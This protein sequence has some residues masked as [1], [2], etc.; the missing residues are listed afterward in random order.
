MMK[1][2]KELSGGRLGRFARRGLML[3]AVTGVVSL[4]AGSFVS[5]ACT[6][7]Y[8]GK[9]VTTDGSILFG[10]TEDISSAHSK[11]FLV[12]E[13]ETHEEGEM[14]EDVTGFTMPLPEYTYRFTT[15]EDDPG[16]GGDLFGEVGTNEYGVSMSATESASPAS[17]LRQQ[18]PFI[19]DTGITESSMVNVV[20]PCVKTAREGIELLA[21]I[22]DTY[23]AGEGNTLMIGD[24]NECWYMEILTGHQYVAIKMPDDKAAIMP[25]CFMLEEVDVSDTENVIASENLFQVAEAAGTLVK[26][27]S[28]TVIHVRKSYSGSMGQGNSYRIWGGQIIFN[29]DL[30]SQIQPTDQ[31][32]PMFVEPSEKVSVKTMYRIAGTRYEGT[33]YENQGT[34]IGTPRSA[35]C[36]IMQIRPDMPVELE[37]I[38]WLCM[39]SAD[40]STFLPFYS[41]AI[42]DTH[43]AYQVGEVNYNEDSAYWTFRGLATLAAS[44][45]EL[46]AP[47]LKAYWSDYMD[48]LIARQA[49]VDEK[50]M[51]LYE[52]NPGAVSSKATDLGIALS[53]DAL[54]TAKTLYGD[55][56]RAFAS[57]DG[58]FKSAFVPQL[59]KNQIYSNYSYDLVYDW[60]EPEPEE[61]FGDLGTWIR[62]M[63]SL[64]KD[65]Y[66]KESWAAL[67]KAV[68]AARAVNANENASRAQIDRAITD[69]IQAFGGLEYGVQ[70]QHLEIA[71]ATA[72][73]ILDAAGDYEE[74]SLA[75]LKAVIEEAQTVLADE[76][77]TQDAV[78]QA[79]SKVIDAIAQVIENADL[80]SLESL[81]KAVESLDA[82]KYTSESYQ[83]LAQAIEAAKQVLADP[84]RDESQLAAAYTQLAE[85]VRGLEMKGNKAALSAVIEKAEGILANAS[86]YTASSISGLEEALAAAKAVYDKDDATMQEIAQAT[87]DLTNVLVQ[88]RLKGDLDQDGRVSTADSALLLQYTAEMADL[89]EAQYEGADVDGNGVVDTKDAVL[90]LQYSA[91]KISAF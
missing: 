32:L 72:Q 44:N 80:S 89:D 16:Y 19:R 68:E 4:A 63:E 36:H 58:S 83:A 15:C 37:T 73:G 39:G 46:V 50:M 87:E 5:L 47:N 21:D 75:A 54:K 66:T 31:D 60:V 26:G 74:E 82:D 85:A 10:R 70:R 88:A 55:M 38:E 69:L 41:A 17:A 35:E 13:A 20:L 18:D 90:I 34:V 12:H 62:F 45:R 51:A 28:D 33:D 24:R 25:N 14:Y 2:Q 6:S 30:L 29:E 56:M 53:E 42:T 67:E 76:N 48:D 77:A 11:I 81:L 43:P 78:N 84:N 59:H 52:S 79:A 86:A 1:K 57:G 3:A 61:V 64:E 9:D 7:Y 71:V 27:D 23:G 8:A 40:L 91:E 49:G 65:E 22:V